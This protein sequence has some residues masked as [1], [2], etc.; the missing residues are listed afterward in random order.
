[1]IFSCLI[2]LYDLYFL[3]L[4]RCFIFIPLLTHDPLRGT[5]DDAFFKVCRLRGIAYDIQNKIGALFFLAD[6]TVGGTLSLLCINKNK[7]KTLELV[8]NTLG[9]VMRNIGMEQASGVNKRYENLQS[10]CSS[11]K[12]ILRNENGGD[13]SKSNIIDLGN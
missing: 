7:I 10:I 4:G 9:F 6:T 8:I 13:L 12:K 11:F 2:N 1:M 5:H 3:I